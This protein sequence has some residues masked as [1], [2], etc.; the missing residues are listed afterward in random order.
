[1]SSPSRLLRSRRP[2]PLPTQYT[3]YPSGDISE[4]ADDGGVETCDSST[5]SDAE[6]SPGRISY[7]CPSV[8]IDITKAKILY[9][10]QVIS[11]AKLVVYIGKNY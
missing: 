2:I 6:I 3:W 7:T 11:K 4:H 5:T 9:M 8:G 10:L 1:M